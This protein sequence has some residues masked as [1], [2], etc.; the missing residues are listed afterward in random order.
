MVTPFAGN[1][2]IS[3]TKKIGRAMSVFFK[4]VNCACYTHV[5]KKASI[6]CHTFLQISAW[7][8]VQSYLG[9]CDCAEVHVCKL[10][11]KSAPPY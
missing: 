2:K 11:T 4:H 7:T 10:Y 1:H 9:K 5:E 8:L 3:G 6:H